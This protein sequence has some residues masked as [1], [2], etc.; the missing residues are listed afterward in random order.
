MVWRFKVVNV[1]GASIVRYFERVIA[2]IKA[3]AVGLS[4]NP[5]TI[6]EFI[7][8]KLVSFGRRFEAIILSLAEKLALLADRVQKSLQESTLLASLLI[9]LLLTLAMLVAIVY[10]VILLR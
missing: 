8:V 5:P 7:L 9:G 10:S 3:G 6:L 4:R 1:V 2:K